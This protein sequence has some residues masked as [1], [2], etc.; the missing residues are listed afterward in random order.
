MKVLIVNCHPDTSDVGQAVFHEFEEAVRNSLAST[1]DVVE[2]HVAGMD[3]LDD[4]LYIS[5][6]NSSLA[7]MPKRLK[8]SLMDK[9]ALLLFDRLDM[10]FIDGP[11]VL[12]PWAPAARKAFVL[13]HMCFETG[14]CLFGSAFT[15]HML[16]YMAAT[17]GVYERVGWS[18]S[19]GGKLDQLNTLSSSRSRFL[20]NE[21]G[22][23]YRKV[24]SAPAPVWEPVFNVGLRQHSSR[25]RSHI[26]YTP[27]IPSSRTSRINVHFRA[28]WLFADM[29]SNE[30]TVPAKHSWDI[31][32]SPLAP[33]A[34]DVLAANDW[35]PT[36]I[37]YGHIVA[38]KF[39]VTPKAEAT[40]LLLHNYVRHKYSLMRKVSHLEFISQLSYQQTLQEGSSLATARSAALRSVRSRTQASR[41]SVP[42]A[43]SPSATSPGSASLTAE[44]EHGALPELAAFRPPDLPTSKW[45]MMQEEAAL[46]GGGGA[47]QIFVETCEAPLAREPGE[48]QAAPSTT[49]RY[50]VNPL[51]LVRMGATKDVGRETPLDSLVSEASCDSLTSSRFVPRPP[52]TASPSRRSSLRGGRAKWEASKSRALHASGRPPV[53]V[54]RVPTGRRKP[55]SSWAKFRAR[56]AHADIGE[57]MS[58]RFPEADFVATQSTKVV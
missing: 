50:A 37:E 9:R 28:H 1:G 29:T 56:H 5:P 20:N 25:N 48:W 4:Y 6:A 43:F 17:G 7:P 35:T 24:S 36:I 13:L 44:T 49:L 52:T 41:A 33:V 42:S 34:V 39:D 12:A 58:Y 8:E 23:V 32:L 46:N 2:V 57:A 47:M 30:F 16:T 19:V 15:A 26:R 45:K 53:R 14:K 38:C 54:V 21:T 51:W 18:G 55:Y 10:I 11:H 40:V 3:D 27:R 31:C 22:D